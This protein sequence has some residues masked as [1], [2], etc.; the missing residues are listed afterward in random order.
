MYKALIGGGLA[1][2]L[3]L[4]SSAASP[5]ALSAAFVA[6]ALLCAAL[7]SLGWWP[8]AAAGVVGLG[9]GV[10]AVWY[11]DATSAVKTL[12]SLSGG[13]LIGLVLVRIGL[14][15]DRESRWTM[16]AGIAIVAVVLRA[17]TLVLGNPRNG[18]LD[19]PGL[20]AI[21]TGEWGRA[22]AVV[23]AGLALTG[24]QAVR[25]HAAF[26]R[27]TRRQAWTW[28]LVMVAPT[29]VLCI[30]MI[31]LHDLGPA[32]V[33]SSAIAV[34]IWRA[35]GARLA[36]PVLGVAALALVRVGTASTAWA[37]RTAEIRDPRGDQPLRQLAMA[38][39]SMGDTGLIG[40]GHGSGSLTRVVPVG[41]S[42]YA[43]ATIVGDY[44]MAVAWIAVAVVLGLALR[45]TWEST[46][47]ADAAGLIALGAGW[48]LTATTAWVVLGNVGLMPFTGINAP[49]LAMSGSASGAVGVLLGAAGASL[50]EP[51]P[52]EPVIGSR[53][54]GAALLATGLAVLAMVGMVGQGLVL[55]V[56]AG[57]GR[58]DAESSLRLKRG[59]LLFADGTTLATSNSSGFRTTVDPEVSRVLGGYDRRSLTQEGL[60]LV[61]AG[62]TTC[63]DHR[64]A[65]GRLITIGVRSE[66]S[67]ADTVTSL[68]PT[69]QRAVERSVAATSSASI[70]VLDRRSNGV[71]AAGAGATSA[72]TTQ[73]H[74]PEPVSVF[75]DAAPPGSTFKIVTA[76]AAGRHG[77]DG[78]GEIPA[79]LAL[80]GGGSLSNAWDGPCPAPGVVAMLTYSCNTTA[81][82]LAMRVGRSALTEAADDLGF[83]DAGLTGPPDLSLSPVPL[84]WPVTPRSTTGLD[85]EANGSPAGLARTGI[86]QQGVQATLAAVANVFATALSGERRAIP[87]VIGVC[88]RDGLQAWTPPA[89]PV[90]S[91]TELDPIREG[92]QG[93]VQ[94]GTLRSLAPVGAVAGKTGTA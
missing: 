51:E 21:M 17:S 29:V 93:A 10:Q 13:V 85:L 36:L 78:S 56:T 88:E 77:V 28:A 48:T 74:S 32:V 27:I 84:R 81:G 20:P 45:I 63:G 94:R 11:G 19:L 39:R 23:A 82:F 61:A 5:V 8:V 50:A 2:A 4:V 67:P 91:S 24:S 55:T 44:G 79:P 15:L 64:D 53:P 12:V 30:V 52:T 76:Y 69:W 40:G 58:L 37:E 7:P 83:R 66:C 59:A 92:L 65:L 31:A 70:L 46:Q 18:S 41:Q 22:L 47:N 42:D 35:L 49:L 68:E 6:G 38:L 43:V 33:L 3:L 73:D 14:R 72:W 89:T 1:A 60:E 26:G 86:G 80:P 16:A 87:A 9:A 25:R 57:G 34:M 54:R 71:I 62:A 90:T 75:V